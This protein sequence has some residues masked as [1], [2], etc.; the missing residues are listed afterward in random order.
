[1]RLG[2]FAKTFPGNDP[3]TAMRAARDA[4]YAS[5]QYNMA[6][7]GLASMPDAITDE[8]TAAI[9]AA[10]RDTG[11]AVAA[12]SGTYN[13]IHPDPAVRQAGLRRLA[14]L[15]DAAAAIGTGM[16]TLCTGTRD[17]NDQ[18]RHHPDNAAPEAWHDLMEE[19]GKAVTL[20]EA[21][22]I[23]LGIEPELANV[24]SDARAARRLLDD[25]QSPSLRIVL[26]PANLFETERDHARIIAEAIDLL[27]GDIGMA[28]AKDRD[29]SGA[30]V[31]A[32][33]GVV[34][35]A[36]FTKRLRAAGFDGDLVTHGLEAT[37]AP[38]VAAFLRPLAR[39]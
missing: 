19:M 21:K 12:V 30:F 29:P 2:I 35:F 5:V 24:V 26:D 28:H 17:A 20:A 10:S 25:L 13:M 18:W 39:S 7:S 8:Q 33:R 32:G 15:I 6:C 4:G 27:A 3:L 23:A 1:M 38:A 16:V 34:D 37:E 31:A 11:V 14:V 36:D 22:D 9:S